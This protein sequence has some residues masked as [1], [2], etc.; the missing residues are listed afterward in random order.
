MG[1]T[2]ITPL[3]R[4]ARRG[5]SATPHV[6]SGH[7]VAGV[8]LARLERALELDA[9]RLEDGRYLVT[10]GREPHYVDVR[11]S[12]AV[13]CDCGDMAWRGPPFLGPCKHVLRVRLACGDPIVLRA[14]G[15]LLAGLRAYVRTLED[16]LR[17][18]PIRLTARLRGEVADTLARP[19]ATLRFDRPNPDHDPTVVVTDVS[20]GELLGSIVRTAAGPVF[21]PEAARAAA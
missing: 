18:P 19:E 7:Q 13:A 20:T 17:P 21:A 15:T 3:P 14:A 6:F 10:G 8:E 16:R 4:S 1:S 11:P 12:A 2:D 5:G 9:E